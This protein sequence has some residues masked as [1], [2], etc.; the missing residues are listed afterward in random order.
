MSLH[1]TWVHGTSVRPQW[2]ADRLAQ[3]HGDV[4]DAGNVNIPYSDYNGSPAGWGTTYR[5]KRSMTGWLG[6]TTVVPDPTGANPFAGSLKGY[7]FHFSIPTPVIVS[8]VR[9]ALQK[10]FVMWSTGANTQ[11]IAIH[12]WDGPN[13]FFTHNFDPNT[14]SINHSTDL[15]EN[16]TM[17]TLPTPHSMIFGLG[18][19]VGVAFLQDSDVTFFSAGA[20][21]EVAGR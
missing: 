4:W 6:G 17:F 19:S 13:R 21:F 18:I 12:L 9:S 14:G 11:M 3:V 10:A 8:G 7:W 1:A 5:G 16:K 2:I 20:D 15:T